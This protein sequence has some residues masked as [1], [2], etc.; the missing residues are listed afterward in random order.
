MLKFA[1][2]WQISVLVYACNE[3]DSAAAT[4]LNTWN[5]CHV[6]PCHCTHAKHRLVHARKCCTHN[7]IIQIIL[8]YWEVKICV[9]LYTSIWRDYV[10]DNMAQLEVLMPNW[11]YICLRESASNYSPVITHSHACYILLGMHLVFC[12][13]EC[14]CVCVLGG[15]GIVISLW[16]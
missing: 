8:L 13:C 7:I 16:V 10:L 12:T 5:T 15:G 1:Y 6:I 4:S 14:V 9:F 11:Y 3:D 2:H